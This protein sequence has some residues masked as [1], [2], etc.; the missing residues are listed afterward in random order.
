[1]HAQKLFI[2]G[3]MNKK[4]ILKSLQQAKPDH[5]E[6]IK[7]GHKI[8]K[9]EPQNSLKKPVLC[10]DCGFGKWY[11]HEGYKLVNIPQLLE[12]EVL[13]KEIH[14]T[15]TILY[16]ITF[17]RRIKPRTTLISGG[18]EVPVEETMFRQKKLKQL[19][20]K[21]ITLIRA[22]GDIEKKVDAMK[23]NDF[24]SGWFV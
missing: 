18:I 1:M 7:Q 13:H 19:E 14:K 2:L 4:H 21:T 22:L 17:D 6:W 23:D 20:K 3:K 10:T 16:Y 9:G 11:Y 24:Q 5:I 8:L 15:Y 12:I